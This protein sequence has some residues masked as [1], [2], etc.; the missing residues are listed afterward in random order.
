MRM[1]IHS[2]SCLQNKNMSL[3]IM[4]PMKSFYCTSSYS[5]CYRNDP[6]TA[7]KYFS[8]FI[9]VLFVQSSAL[10][11]SVFVWNEAFA[12]PGSDKL[13][14]QDAAV[15][16]GQGWGDTALG[17]PGQPFRRAVSS[18]ANEMQIRSPVFW[19]PGLL[20]S[21]HISFEGMKRVPSLPLSSRALCGA[22][23][24]PKEGGWQFPLE[25]VGSQASNS[26]AVGNNTAS[27]HHSDSHQLLWCDVPQ[28]SCVLV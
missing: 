5:S 14:S 28:A 18:K 6:Q 21:S 26:P 25:S 11:V 7:R 16:L 4:L 2:M 24:F 23:Q 8:T 13:L 22:S 27:H 19:G 3:S 15:R 20:C 10:D 9:I 17:S 1:C 12:L